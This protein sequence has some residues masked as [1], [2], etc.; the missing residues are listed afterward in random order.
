MEGLE[1]ATHRPGQRQTVPG[2]LPAART[3][4]ASTSG[5]LTQAV[6]HNHFSS[7][8]FETQRQPLLRLSA[9]CLQPSSTGD[10]AVEALSAQAEARLWAVD[11]QNT[12]H[13]LRDA[14][15]QCSSDVRQQFF[16]RYAYSLR[17]YLAKDRFE[18]VQTHILNTVIYGYWIWISEINQRASRE[19][20]AT[21]S[22]FGLLV[23]SLCDWTSYDPQLQRR[24]QS[25]RITGGNLWEDLANMCAQ[26]SPPFVISQLPFISFTD[27][28]ERNLL[29]W[30][31]VKGGLCKQASNCWSSFITATALSIPDPS[32]QQQRGVNAL[33]Q[34]AEV[35]EAL[36]DWAARSDGD[37]PNW[38]SSADWK[39]L[40]SHFSIASPALWDTL[41]RNLSLNLEQSL[42]EL[43]RLAQAFELRRTPAELQDVALKLLKCWN[44]LTCADPMRHLS[45]DLHR[46]EWYERL[47]KSIERWIGQADQVGNKEFYDL[48]C[49]VLIPYSQL[50]LTCLQHQE[51]R[52]AYRLINT[53]IR[54]QENQLFLSIV[55][56]IIASL[57][58][59]G[60]GIRFLMDLLN[61]NIAPP[62]H[63]VAALIPPL[64]REPDMILLYPDLSKACWTRSNGI[65]ATDRRLFELPDIDKKAKILFDLGFLEKCKNRAP[66][67]GVLD[68]AKG[69]ASEDR[70]VRAG[71]WILANRK[72]WPNYGDEWLSSAE[73]YKE[74]NT[75]LSSLIE[76]AKTRFFP[77][78]PSE[79]DQAPPPV[80]SAEPKVEIPTEASQGLNESKESFS[81]RVSATPSIEGESS[82]VAVDSPVASSMNQN[83][84]EISDAT[85]ILTEKPETPKQ[86]FT[87]LLKSKAFDELTRQVEERPDFAVHWDEG[88]SSEQAVNRAIV[89]A[90]EVPAMVPHLMANLG[91]LDTSLGR[92][93]EC[94]LA[95]AKAV[96]SKGDSPLAKKL[97]QFLAAAP[98]QRSRWKTLNATQQSQLLDV[99]LSWS[100]ELS[101]ATRS[102][103][104]P[105]T[106]VLFCNA[107]HTPENAHSRLEQFFGHYSEDSK[108]WQLETILPKLFNHCSFVSINTQSY[109]SS[110]I[111]RMPT[112]Y[113]CYSVM[114]LAH[115][116]GMPGLEGQLRTLAE[117][118]LLQTE[119]PLTLRDRKS[120]AAHLLG[121][122][123]PI[124][125][126]D[127]VAFALY[128]L[129]LELDSKNAFQATL[130]G[131]LDQTPTGARFEELLGT[132]K[133][134]DTLTSMVTTAALHISSDNRSSFAQAIRRTL[135]KEALEKVDQTS[136]NAENIRYLLKTP[137]LLQDFNSLIGFLKVI[138]RA[139]DQKVLSDVDLSV[140]LQTCSQ[141]LEQLT[142]AVDPQTF[143]KTFQ[144]RSWLD[145]L[146][147]LQDSASA[148]LKKTLGSCL[149]NYARGVLSVIKQW[150]DEPCFG[151]FLFHFQTHLGKFS[152]QAED[153]KEF[154]D[155]FET[156]TLHLAGA[157]S[158]TLRTNALQQI[159][160]REAKHSP[161]LLE[162]NDRTRILQAV[163][164]QLR[165]E[166]VEEA[167]QLLEVIAEISELP[168][169]TLPE[170]AQAHFVELTLRMKLDP[171][172]ERLYLDL[173]RS[174]LCFR[175]RYKSNDFTW[176]KKQTRLMEDYIELMAD[177]KDPEFLA[178]GLQLMG[179]GGSVP[180]NLVTKF[181]RLL[182][183]FA[184]VESDSSDQ[185]KKYL[186]LGMALSLHVDSGLESGA[187][188]SLL[189]HHPQLVSTFEDAKQFY[190]D[191][192]AEKPGIT[193][194]RAINNA[195]EVGLI[196]SFAMEAHLAKFSRS[197]KWAEPKTSSAL[198]T[199]CQRLRNHPMIQLLLMAQEPQGLIRNSI[200]RSV[201]H[202]SRI[203]SRTGASTAPSMA[204]A[205]KAA[206][207]IMVRLKDQTSLR[208]SE[209]ELLIVAIESH[210]DHLVHAAEIDQ[211][212]IE[213]L[214]TLAQSRNVYAVDRHR[215]KKFL[216]E[217][218]SN[219]VL[220]ATI[221][222]K[223]LDIAISLWGLG[224]KIIPGSAVSLDILQSM[225]LV[226][227]NVLPH[228][229]LTR[230]MALWDSF[231]GLHY[232]QE[233]DLLKRRLDAVLSE[234]PANLPPIAGRKR[235]SASSKQ[236][237]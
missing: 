138:Q 81:P 137:E 156:L 23:K 109:A 107:T 22:Q 9:Y 234:P 197:E 76:A 6:A 110:L 164:K 214:L 15:A 141:R 45:T 230:L 96:G 118:F 49:A 167:K 51:S 160:V 59:T 180:S 42:D 121:I 19:P 170:L 179:D 172:P 125:I 176:N 129:A 236:T 34:M 68:E 173:A 89:L 206:D 212:K 151:E 139:W 165:S 70:L 57:N 4:P 93:G 91:Y 224:D 26:Y 233:R 122:T 83:P 232:P 196:V 193:R 2:I 223:N 94:V 128:K 126:E 147:A 54:R 12:L 181:D 56:L 158:V 185:S 79:G 98:K 82:K 184:V 195:Y 231:V 77:Q 153:T 175:H 14:A 85:P 130:F 155:V 135:L 43:A 72:S 100:P 237:T 66:L 146:M 18:V 17:P 186:I 229:S 219:I 65:K 218:M 208:A 3:T 39:D 60:P 183:L 174:I 211:S 88:L 32:P 136:L 111:N 203:Y 101:I 207:P 84:V 169:D 80:Q 113:T 105:L 204:Y 41:L 190:A 99:L 182:R 55:P 58:P 154:A 131:R 209:T 210:C 35:L 157:K 216:K 103:F 10:S 191:I 144:N 104:V 1:D 62:P 71:K 120:L 168:S 25:A 166:S 163:L 48:E 28:A 30:L 69:Q 78:P 86:A 187:I 226:A 213:N 67:N 11:E 171:P 134:P 102:H 149:L 133:S 140:S 64:L 33:I 217:V 61:G 162:P 198:G 97:L 177:A 114:R 29:A 202:L 116:R 159:F 115:E 31:Y 161:Q 123:P 235:R 90:N 189:G 145:P 200:Q 108:E 75:E 20:E 38:P 205:S 199:R 201:L 8:P 222:G 221:Q 225:I 220:R 87:R 188:G 44:D 50:A 192:C 16:L 74:V 178:F 21:A 127:S 152:P 27:P 47:R 194:D 13:S 228:D 5:R 95:L 143:K 52:P 53:L 119:P 106:N 117:L 24:M 40:F 92:G 132:L 142:P 227:K 148:Q 7:I 73:K 46:A 124:E 215:Q 63:L 112:N 37:L 150:N 36:S